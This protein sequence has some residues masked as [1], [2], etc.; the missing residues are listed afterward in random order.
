MKYISLLTCMLWFTAITSFSQK[1]TLISPNQKINV[2]L[3]NKQNAETGEWCLKINYSD[4]GKTTEAIPQIALGL[5]RAEPSASSS[6]SAAR[7]KPPRR[8]AVPETRPPAYQPISLRT[9]R[10]INRNPTSPRA[11]K[12]GLGFEVVKTVRPGQY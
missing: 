10:R 5:S 8:K 7:L 4:N 6:A 3:F 1:V 2:A 11:P 9:N 12:T